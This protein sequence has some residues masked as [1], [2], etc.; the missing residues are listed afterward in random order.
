MKKLLCLITI[1]GLHLQPID[2]AMI[3]SDENIEHSIILDDTISFT[4]P[5]TLNVTLTDD[6]EGVVIYEKNTFSPNSF[7]THTMTENNNNPYYLVIT[8]NEFAFE[9]PNNI[10]IINNNN[11][12][13]I[14]PLYQYHIKTKMEIIPEQ[15]LCGKRKNNSNTYIKKE[16]KQK[17]SVTCQLVHNKNT[18]EPTY[19]VLELKFNKLKHLLET[20][21]DPTIRHCVEAQLAKM[22]H[23]NEGPAGQDPNR[24]MHALIYSFIASHK[25]YNKIAQK[26]AEKIYKE[27]INKKY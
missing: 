10:Q 25:T 17:N 20:T 14:L 24:L 19:H 8:P 16:K 15:K 26:R 9:L 23:E 1:Y 11:S 3:I 22:Y 2:A 12:L 21:A 13:T 18:N 27:I 4:I 7:E 6:S 5:Y